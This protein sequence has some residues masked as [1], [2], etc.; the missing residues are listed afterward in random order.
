MEISKEDLEEL[1]NI[2]KED[3]GETLSDAEAREMGQRL[4][5]LFRIICQPLPP[6]SKEP[7]EI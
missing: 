6:N 1:K 7:D 4:I 3:Y 2:Y 5:N